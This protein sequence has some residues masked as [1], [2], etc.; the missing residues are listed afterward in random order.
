MSGTINYDLMTK[1]K[2]PEMNDYKNKI[3][4]ENFSNR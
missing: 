2:I 4:K 3:A 1:Y